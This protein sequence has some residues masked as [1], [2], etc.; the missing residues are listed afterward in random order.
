MVYYSSSHGCHAKNTPILMYNGD[1]KKVQDVKVGD[2]LMGDDSTPRNVLR[3]AR[4]RQ[5]MVK[6]IPNK[7]EEFVVNYHHY[8][9][10]KYSNTNYFDKRVGKYVS[11]NL[12]KETF[13]IK[14]TLCDKKEDSIKYTNDRKD[15]VYR[16]RVDKY[17]NLKSHITERLMLYRNEVSFPEKEVFEP[18][19]IGLWLGDGNS[20][21]SAITTQ[22]S[23]VIK[24]LKE[25]LPKHNLYLQHHKSTNYGYRVNSIK[26][27][28]YENTF[29]KTLQNYNMIKNKHIPKDYKCNSK[30]NRLQLLAGLIDSDGYYDKKN[31]YYEIVQKNETLI[32]DII[33]LCRSLGFAAYKKIK[34]INNVKYYRLYVYGDGIENI[35]CV[36]KRKKSTYRYKKKNARIVGFNTRILNED[37]YYGFTLDCNNRFIQGDFITSFNTGKSNYTK[38]LSNVIG[39]E[40]S[41]FGSLDQIT[42]THTHA[43]VGK[44]INVI[45]EVDRTQTRTKA[46]VIKDFSQREVAIYNEKNR[47]QHR[48]KCYVRYM[49]TTNY[50]DGVFFDNEDR[51]YVIYTFEK[52]TDM[53]YV[54]RL[55]EVMED[56]TVV[57][58]YGKYL[59]NYKITMDR[60][61]DWIRGRY[62]SEDYYNMMNEDSVDKFLKDL[63]KLDTLDMEH[64]GRDEYIPSIED[65]EGNFILVKKDVF[66]SRL[67]KEYC[68]EN[69]N[70]F[71]KQAAKFHKQISANYKREIKPDVRIG[72][73]KYYK[74]NLEALYE[75]FFPNEKF[76]NHHIKN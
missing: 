7:G 26:M 37:N 30:E 48:I 59:E 38:F 61:N 45:E 44:L 74:L 12:D 62:L 69:D 52:V 11:I 18:W 39:P 13:K 10:L 57:Y 50:Q 21:N 49:M 40:L 55:Q 43:H 4:G 58:L 8:L 33:Y 19:L 71:T 56:K 60:P 70:G 36:I 51:R 54:N 28:R 68:R 2:V 15:T 23:T 16:I 42:E 53:N 47:P 64:Y 14:R 67:Y 24:K 34:T 25:I 65:E 72:K 66:Y 32:N 17:L 9:A 46:N 29:L 22:D 1:I 3:L 63:V 75:K 76:T 31:H 73:R 6:I 41:Y 5:T 20:R 35:P 27:H